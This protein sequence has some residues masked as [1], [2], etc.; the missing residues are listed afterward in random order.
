MKRLGLA[1]ALVLSALVAARLV[2]ADAAPATSPGELTFSTHN[3]VYNAEGSF[4]SWRFTKVDIPNGDLTKGTVVIEV[5]L[6]SVNEKAAKLA[7]HLRTADFFDVATFPKAT[8]VI[9]GAVSTAEK[10][11][12]ATAEVDLHGV[13]GSCPVT[14]EVVSEAP[15]TIKGTATLDRTTFKVGEPYDAANKYSPL[16]AVAIGLNAKLQ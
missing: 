16:A 1:S 9:S 12:K 15:L 14:F 7:A 2:A 11:Y 8:I 4:G 13:K 3:S 5:D 6:E 10:H